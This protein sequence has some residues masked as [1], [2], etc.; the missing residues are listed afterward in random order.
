VTF[1][2]TTQY[3]SV[4]VAGLATG[5]GAWSL[6][7]WFK[8]AANPAANATLVSFGTYGT[9]KSAAGIGMTTGGGIFVSSYSADT[10]ATAPVTLNVWHHAA[11]TWDGTT[12]RIYLDGVA[13]PTATPGAL[14][15]GTH[16][17]AFVASETGVAG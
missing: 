2:G 15:V 12:L 6:E 3:A 8:I 4:P 16:G 13:S 14:T 9:A 1:N 10:A 7:C 5:N 17:A 11:A